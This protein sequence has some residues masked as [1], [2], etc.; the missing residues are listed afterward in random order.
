MSKWKPELDERY[1]IPC[2][3]SGKG[4]FRCCRWI[5]DELDYLR[6]EAGMV[7]ESKEKAIEMAEKTLAAAKEHV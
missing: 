4:N 5:N 3:C 7:C 1:Y 6:Y 2:V